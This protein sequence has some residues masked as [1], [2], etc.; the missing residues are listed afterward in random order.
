M[1]RNDMTQ[2][3][4]ILWFTM[5]PANYYSQLQIYTPTLQACQQL[6]NELAPQLLP[7]RVECKRVQL[8]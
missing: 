1:F 7:K 4:L 8:T 3:I 5:T 2:Y 6:A